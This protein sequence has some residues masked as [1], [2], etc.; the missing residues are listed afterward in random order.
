MTQNSHK[1]KIILALDT[2]DQNAA[3]NLCKEV[4]ASV[5]MVKLGLE[6]FISFGAAGVNLIKQN[7]GLEIFL[8]LKLHDIP[9]TVAK[10][11]EAVTK[12]GVKMLTLHTGGGKEMLVAAKNAA[13][14]TAKTLGIEPP[15][16]LGV[17]VLTSFDQESLASVG[18]A[19]NLS[20]QVLRLAAIAKDADLD[21]IVCS[22]HEIELIKQ[23]FGDNL[24][25]IVPGIRTTNDQRQ[26]QK[27][28]MTPKEALTKGADFLVIGRPITGAVD[29]KAAAGEILAACG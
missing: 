2:Q 19:G 14:K 25:I 20:E 18:I 12:L 9:N 10:A 13:T 17:T 11:T 24:K 3:L 8:D 23:N 22:A 6:F 26:D 5:G 4:A 1:K 15:M 28:V 21:G 29:P 7:T 16:L 27:R